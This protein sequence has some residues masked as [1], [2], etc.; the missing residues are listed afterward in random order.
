MSL[1]DQMQAA[2]KSEHAIKSDWFKLKE[3]KNQFR[4]LTEP[5]AIFEDFTRGM[6]FT[7]CGFQGSMKFM[8]Y[9]L[10][11]ADNEVRLAKLPKLIGDKLV[12]WEEDD[13]MPI[14]GYP[15]GYDVKVS[16]ENAGTKEVK[17]SV[18][19]SIKQVAVDDSIVAELGK[20]KTITDIVEAM[21]E[22]SREKNGVQRLNPNTGAH[23]HKT[24]EYPKNE[25]SLDDIPF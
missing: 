6:C 5:V 17:Y 7:G 10:D 1:K 8:C 9:V 19:R 21:K 20:R 16:A 24:I 25:I 22:K 18:D 14:E 4:V 15:M 13:E 2:E 3:G 23:A 11:R 12:H